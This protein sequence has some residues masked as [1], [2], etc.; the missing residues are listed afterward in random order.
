[1]K[2]ITLHIA[3]IPTEQAN[4]YWAG[5]PDAIG[6]MPLEYLADTV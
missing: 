6:Q 1:M 4:A 5:G 2:S 3:P